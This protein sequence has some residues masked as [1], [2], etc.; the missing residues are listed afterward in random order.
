MK[1]MKPNMK[2]LLSVLIVTLSLG[3]SAYASHIPGGNL[4]YTCTGTPNQYLLTME[5]F[6]KCPSTL[7]STQSSS[8]VT[9][10]NNCG[11]PNPASVTFNQ[12]GV[13]EDVTQTCA[14]QLSNCPPNPSGGVQGVLMYTYEALITFPVVWAGWFICFNLCFRENATNVSV[15]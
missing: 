4:T 9:I 7:P 6:V 1:F 5:L 12:V 8:Y 2:N 11:L 10:T 15:N 3:F 14:S 13:R